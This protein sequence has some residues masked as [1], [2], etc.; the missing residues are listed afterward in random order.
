MS[1]IG[2]SDVV[3]IRDIDIWCCA[4]VMIKRYGDA[5]DIEAARRADEY[6]A[7]GER[8]GQRVWLRIAQAIDDLRTVKPGE[9]KN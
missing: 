4:A 7:L 8:D 6:E 5:A 3:V 9:P 1:A 2:G